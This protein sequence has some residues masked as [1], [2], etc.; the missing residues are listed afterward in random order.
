MN[1]TVKYRPKSLDEVVGHEKIIK[2]LKK[3]CVLREFP[4]TFLF[5]GK[6]G[7]GKTTLQRIMAKNILCLS[8]DKEGNS[9]NKCEICISI[10]NEKINNYYYEFNGSNLGI[11]EMRSIESLATV[12]TLSQTKAKV[13]VIDELQELSANKK[14]QKNILK[15]LESPLKNT[16]FILSTMDEYKVDKAILNRAVKYKLQDLSEKEIGKYLIHIC[17]EEKI[18]LT[19]QNKIQTLVTLVQNSDGSV[20]TAVSYLERIIYSDLWNENEI[21]K[22]LGIISQE[23][24]SII[25]NQLLSG[26]VEIFENKI[27]LNVLENINDIL[28]LYYKVLSGCKIETWQK[29]KITYLKNFS[30]QKVKYAITRLAEL[31]KY[32]YINQ[33]LIDFAVV[34]IINYCKGNENENEN[35]E[36][37]S[38]RRRLPK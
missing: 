17:K 30:V 4:N 24:I 27:D 11:E 12:K 3:R 1:L 35:N 34:D 9:C 15:I 29:S 20:R 2:E 31:L 32:N 22:E 8:V 18:D 37:I 16:Y 23:K 21:I 5:S 7:T 6:T 14:A 10:D 28:L 26:N 25:V 33:Y 13:I 19:D 36:E 38:K